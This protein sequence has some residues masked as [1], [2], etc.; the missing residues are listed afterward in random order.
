M[1]SR[2]LNSFKVYLHVFLPVL[3]LAFQGLHVGDETHCFRCVGC[4]NGLLL[5]VTSR[6]KKK[7][8]VFPQELQ[9]LDHKTPALGGPTHLGHR[10]VEVCHLV[11][12]QVAKLAENIFVPRVVLQRH[13]RLHFSKLDTNRTKFVFGLRCVECLSRQPAKMC[14]QSKERNDILAFPEHKSPDWKISEVGDN[15]LHKV[16][17]ENNYS[18][19]LLQHGHPLADVLSDSAVNVIRLKI[20]QRLVLQP[21]L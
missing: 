3:H 14:F 20:P 10:S 21:F 5:Q 4:L 15:L 1:V 6:L 2:I 12:E 17:L 7:T 19:D 9:T 13:L 11:A 16:L 18:L 8:F